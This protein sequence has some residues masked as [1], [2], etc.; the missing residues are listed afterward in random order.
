MMLKIT[1]FNYLLAHAHIRYCKSE[2]IKIK[3]NTV[4]VSSVGL[5][6][7][8]WLHYYTMTQPILQYFNIVE[9][10]IEQYVNLNR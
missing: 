1:L 6:N 3:V 5:K 2:K 7:T 4:K 8:Q 9:I 10:K